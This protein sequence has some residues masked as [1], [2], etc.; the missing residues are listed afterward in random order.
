MMLL[1][2]Y[3]HTTQKLDK[4]SLWLG[5]ERTDMSGKMG[6]LVNH[7]EREGGEKGENVC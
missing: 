5:M 7:V 6:W 4:L 2:K 1:L 3:N